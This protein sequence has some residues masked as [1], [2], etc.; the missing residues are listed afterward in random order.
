MAVVLEGVM[1]RVIRLPANFPA[2][3]QHP[4][5][6]MIVQLLRIALPEHSHVVGCVGINKEVDRMI[7]KTELRNQVER[8]TGESVSGL[9]I[10]CTLREIDSSESP[11]YWGLIPDDLLKE[12]F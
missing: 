8:I 9:N 11:V 5:K 7:T 1:P 10:E 4:G 2:S 12:T 6:E 3:R